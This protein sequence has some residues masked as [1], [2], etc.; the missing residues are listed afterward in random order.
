VLLGI[1]PRLGEPHLVDR[2]LWPAVAGL[3]AVALFV[4][5]GWRAPMTLALAGAALFAGGSSID[6]MVRRR[7]DRL[8]RA[9]TSTRPSRPTPLVAMSACVAHLG[10][11]LLVL[12]FAGSS[13]GH[14]QIAL[15][16]AGQTVTVDGIVVRNLGATAEPGPP[17]RVVVPVEIEASG[18]VHHEE[19]SIV[20]FPARGQ[21][22]SENALWSTPGQDVQVAVR[23]AD[24][25][26]AALLEIHVR[27]L[28]WCVWWG[29]LVMAAGGALA[30]AGR[31]R[32]PRPTA[33]VPIPEGAGLGPSSRTRSCRVR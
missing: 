18:R 32:T 31:R 22:L 1:G 24:D 9:T 13:A 2:L 6:A 14:D 7:N 12:G 10:F 5:M 4:W 11:A 20:G 25:A 27:P 15:V 21:L 3:A 26:G 29:A 23:R 33:D 19:P 30:L 28:A 17:P 8:G 16:A